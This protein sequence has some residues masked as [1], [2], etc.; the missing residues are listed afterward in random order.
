[1]HNGLTE[2]LVESFPNIV[3][4][5]KPDVKIPKVLNP[6]WISGFI[7]G[8]GCFIVHTQN[9]INSKLGKSVKLQFKITQNKRDIEILKLIIL[10]FNCGKLK[11]DRDCNIVTITKF[12]DIIDNLIPFLQKHPLEDIKQLNLVD[13]IKVAEL[14]KVKT[15]LTNEGLNEILRIKSGMNRGRNYDNTFVE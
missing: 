2:T 11:T 8:E 3:A 4:A 13:F 12:T 15:H 1:M 10:Y 9:A 5:P 7:D 6:Y 14:I